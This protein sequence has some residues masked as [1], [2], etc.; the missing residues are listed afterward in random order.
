ME[1]VHKILYVPNGQ[2]A[3]GH[4]V[5]GGST[6]KKGIKEPHVSTS[7]KGRSWKR[8]CDVLTAWQTITKGLRERQRLDLL[9]DY[10]V[11]TFELVTV[12][13]MTDADLSGDIEIKTEKYKKRKLEDERRYLVY[14]LDAAKSDMNRYSQSLP[15]LE[16]EIKNIETK[17]KS[18]G[19]SK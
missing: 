2:Y 11:V 9:A 14:R 16:K 1:Q 18:Y 4:H 17:L 10:R 5:N 13:I 12:E 6:Y 19:D 15:G 7:K 8:Y 3:T